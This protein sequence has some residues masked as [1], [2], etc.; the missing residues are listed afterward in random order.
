MESKTHNIPG[1][2]PGQK[3]GSISGKFPEKS[4]VGQ[5]KDRLSRHYSADDI[6]NDLAEEIHPGDIQPGWCEQ[7]PDEEDN[8]E[9]ARMIG[10]K[11]CKVDFAKTRVP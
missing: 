8:Q 6:L 11:P 5:L 1:Q 4:R 10:M 2:K 3:H 7:I 9:C